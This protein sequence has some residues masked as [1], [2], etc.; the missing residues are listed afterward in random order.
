MV[1][2][3]QVAGHPEAALMVKSICFLYLYLFLYLFLSSYLQAL[4]NHTALVSYEDTFDPPKD[5][6]MRSGEERLDTDSPGD[7]QNQ[8]ES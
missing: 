2:Q 3:F 8:S 4:R 6:L 1:P 7:S 5:S